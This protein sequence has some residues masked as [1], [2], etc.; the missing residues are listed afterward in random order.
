[1]NK[2][3]FEKVQKYKNVD[4]NLPER[5]TKYSAGYDFE[6]PED[7]VIPS[8]LRQMARL[9]WKKIDEEEFIEGLS[10]QEVF[11]LLLDAGQNPEDYT[12]S[13]SKFKASLELK[14]G[15]PDLIEF[16]G[17]SLTLDIDELKVMTKELGLNVT[18]VPTGVKAYLKENQK[19]ELF[20]RS[21]SA[22]NAYLIM[23][24]A[25]GIVDSD[26]VDN[27]SNEGHIAFPIINLSPFDIRI[28]KGETIGQ[29]IIST[30]DRTDD[31]IAEG[32]RDGGFG[33][34]DKNKSEV[35]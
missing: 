9:L 30:F 21:S 12:S 27:K 22:I 24:N 1:M 18:L 35:E 14:K 16:I 29:G 8:H 7:V 6:V 13:P 3:K 25:V 26:Y 5:K 11:K 10:Q 15:L 33:H 17:D 19:L 23:G 34:T 4:F 2:V 31:D 20:V 32:E 28:K